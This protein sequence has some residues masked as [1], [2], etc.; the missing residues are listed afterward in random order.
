L[1]IT[2]A[3]VGAGFMGE[4]H[5]ASYGK[6]SE[7]TVKY[8]CDIDPEKGK[9]LA[10]SAGADYIPDFDVL[11]GRTVDVIDVCLP[12]P[13][14]RPFAVRS[15]EEGFNLFLEK[16]LAIDVEEGSAIA[17][18]ADKASGLSMVGHV[19]RFW[20]GFTELKD[21]VTNG[22]I[23]EPKHALAYRVG[24]PPAW[25]NWYMDMKK[26]NGVIFDLGI[27]DMDFIRWVMGMP[28][29]VYSQ[30]YQR[31]GV[32]T[33]GQVLLD[34]GEGEALVECSWMGSATFPF[35]TYMEIAGTGGLATVNG[36]TNN[37]Y[38][39]FGEETVTAADPYY[40]DGYVRE[41]RHF[42]EC[43]RDGNNPSVPMTEGLETI[44]LSLA[45]VDSAGIGGPVATR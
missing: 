26:S 38:S 2:V 37:S 28:R 41:L 20:P 29:S 30:V 14:H 39:L 45:A 7:A 12:T 6:I 22:E 4:T 1:T 8:V 33:H 35:T 40:E 24:P 3:I 31:D 11:L 42:V 43:V 16:P 15:L 25:A 19:L 27:H 18:A 17:A 10:E 13:L 36:R 44:K 9:P 34:Y 23:G 32:H 5:A 21:R